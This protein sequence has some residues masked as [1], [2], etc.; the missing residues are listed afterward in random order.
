MLALNIEEEP[1][2]RICSRAIQKFANSVGL[3]DEDGLSK[4]KKGNSS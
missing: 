3:M 2:K 4:I 1:K